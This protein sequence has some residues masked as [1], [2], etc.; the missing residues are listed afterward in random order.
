VPRVLD[1]QELQEAIARLRFSQRSG[2]K[3][4]ADR[5]AAEAAAE[6]EGNVL[7]TGLGRADRPVVP[8][9]SCRA[10][11]ASSRASRAASSGLDQADRPGVPGVSCRA[12][13]ASSQASR[14]PAPGASGLPN[15]KIVLDRIEESEAGEGPSTSTGLVRGAQSG[16]PPST[17]SRFTI[18]ELDI[19]FACSEMSGLGEY[20]ERWL[21][22]LESEPEAEHRASTPLVTGL[23]EP[24]LG[25]PSPSPTPSASG[26]SLPTPS[27]RLSSSV[28]MLP[29]LGGRRPVC[30][31]R[32]MQ[33]TLRGL[34]EVVETLVVV[35]GPGDAP[36]PSPSCL[37]PPQNAELESTPE[38]RSPVQ[39]VALPVCQ[40]ST[41]RAEPAHWDVSD[42]PPPVEFQDCEVPVVQAWGLE[43]FLRQLPAVAVPSPSSSMG[44]ESGGEEHE[45]DDDVEYFGD[46][47]LPDM[48]ERRPS[49]MIVGNDVRCQYPFGM[50]PWSAAT[51]LRGYPQ[52]ATDDILIALMNIGRPGATWDDW[53]SAYLLLEGAVVGQRD[54]E[55]QLFPHLKSAWEA[56]MRGAPQ[57]EVKAGLDNMG[58]LLG[59]VHH[60][61][62]IAQGQ[63]VF[64][65]PPAPP[66]ADAPVPA[67]APPGADAPA[68]VPVVD[69][70]PAPA[71]TGADA[72]VSPGSDAPSVVAAQDVPA[73]VHLA[74]TGREEVP[75]TQAPV[76][77]D[78]E[79][80]Q[81]DEDY[82]IVRYDDV[83]G[84]E[85]S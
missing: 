6:E 55:S 70:V 35:E 32:E 68:P 8:G 45:F 11:R 83:S 46:E 21:D 37:V 3:R 36:R 24:P 69:P 7:E 78:Q 67:P 10:D 41:S 33:P 85:Y 16:A 27:F 43:N 13:R 47:P 20:D 2:R 84:E 54:L 18:P 12:T 58:L 29:R 42:V 23:S 5:A 48:K 39:D 64:R 56:L 74:F 38:A 19:S 4:R 60:R 59:R 14:A 15:L 76:P 77:M 49:F 25:R 17:S 30:L 51:V 75:P 26:E 44:V 73:G 50:S 66:G 31:P 72:P 1:A 22:L 40:P 65:P 61:P 80:Y 63:A 28:T 81:S 82:D 71:P 57:I 79:D 62:T 34:Q 52:A 53:R 9:A